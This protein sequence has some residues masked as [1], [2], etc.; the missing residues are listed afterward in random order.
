[1]SRVLQELR[2]LL[3]EDKPVTEHGECVRLRDARSS[4][5]CYCSRVRSMVCRLGGIPLLVFANKQDLLQA[6]HVTADQAS[7]L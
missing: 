5:C 1:M 3:A 7:S 6:C 2:E 4:S